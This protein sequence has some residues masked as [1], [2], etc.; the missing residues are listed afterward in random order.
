VVKYSYI[1]IHIYI[2]IQGVS[3]GIVNILGG[4]SIDYSLGNR[5]IK[6]YVQFSMGVEIQLF[7]V[8]AYRPYSF[9][10]LSVGMDEKRSLQ[11]N[12]KAKRRI[13]HSHYE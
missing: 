10:F 3:E 8:G 1:H 7:E 6:T 9:G 12:S 5:F 4:G 2:Y 11:R 13:G